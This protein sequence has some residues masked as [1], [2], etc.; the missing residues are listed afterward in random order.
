MF[1]VAHGVNH[2]SY[3]D[4]LVYQQLLTL[5]TRPPHLDPSATDATSNT[6]SAVRTI[7]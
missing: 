1:L 6:G 3:R 5:A 2:T 4:T 7:S